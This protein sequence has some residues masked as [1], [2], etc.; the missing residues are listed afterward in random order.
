MYNLGSHHLLCHSFPSVSHGGLWFSRP[1]TSLWTWLDVGDSPVL[2]L[3]LSCF[4]KDLFPFSPSISL[5]VFL[6]SPSWNE[7]PHPFPAVCLLSPL[8][9][10]QGDVLFLAYR[11]LFLLPHSSFL[12]HW[13]IFVPLCSN[14]SWISGPV[15]NQRSL[16]WIWSHPRPTNRSAP[17]TAACQW[18]IKNSFQ[19]GSSTLGGCCPWYR[20]LSC[21]EFSSLHHLP[22]V[23]SWLMVF[24][25]YPA[26]PGRQERKMQEWKRQFCSE[27]C[28]LWKPKPCSISSFTNCLFCQGGWG[29]NICWELIV[30]RLVMVMED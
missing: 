18:Q 29:T 16:V 27:I 25:L 8:P 11:L 21:C 2:L 7:A 9:T 26:K 19:G 23:H 22:A 28:H 1:W 24:H 3:S 14:P 15:L 20:S 13:D 17:G 6:Q 30:S 4:Q 5:S 10:V 12:P